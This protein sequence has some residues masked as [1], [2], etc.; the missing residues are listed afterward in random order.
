MRRRSDPHG[1]GLDTAAFDHIMISYSVSMIPNWKSVLERAA[2]GLKSGGCLH[3]VDFGSQEGLPR[4]AR[5]VLRRWLAMF[6]VTPRDTLESALKSLANRS[7]A[8]LRFTRPFRG[9]AQYGV[10]MFPEQPSAH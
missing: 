3:I 1:D 4:I 6:D 5:S 10:L 7:G 2:I 9:Y 8:R